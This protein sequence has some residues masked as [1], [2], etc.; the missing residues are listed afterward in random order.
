MEV[1]NTINQSNFRF[2][3]TNF[4]NIDDFI[5]DNSLCG[6]LIDCGVSSPQ[7]DEPERGFSFQTKGPLDMRFNQDQ[8]LTCKDIIENYSEKEI[9]EILWKFGEEKESRKIAKF[10][11]KHRKKNTIENT[12]DLAEI[13]KAAKSI[14]TKKHPA[15]K[16]FQAL[17]M[18]VNKEIENLS[19]CLEKIKDKLIKSGKL[20]IITF[21][22]LEDRI[23]KQTFKPKINFHEKNIPLKYK[24]VPDEFK[25]SKI[26]Y[27]SP[28]EIS[29]NPRARSA[30]MRI[31][32][33]L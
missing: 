12:L 15:T 9:A 20:V 3:K 8:R 18:A 21:H 1:A 31:I 33:K 32:E 19:S 23:A 10:I 29:V 27:P 7:L 17:R 13:I 4:S 25:I 11:I 6:V 5:E 22:S 16:S 24:D 2:F 14:K 26:I 30:K 28:E